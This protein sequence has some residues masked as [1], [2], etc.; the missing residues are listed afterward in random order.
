MYVFPE[1]R[2]GAVLLSLATALAAGNLA[3]GR[4]KNTNADRQLLP[5]VGECPP[6]VEPS[7]RRIDG[8][9]NI[10]RLAFP[11]PKPGC[12]P[13][14]TQTV[15]LSDPLDPISGTHTPTVS[16]K[17]TFEV[18][19]FYKKPPY[20]VIQSTVTG[21]EGAIDIGDAYYKTITQSNDIPECPI[22]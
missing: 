1:A 7:L 15:E 11:E 8:S 18:S 6:M 3:C 10:F 12:A 14:T 2:K 4:Q 5:G 13:I 19:C 21:T 9:K 17:D 22:P 16:I 20:A